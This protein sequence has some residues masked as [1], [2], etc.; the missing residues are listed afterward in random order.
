MNIYYKT[1]ENAI[2]SNLARRPF[3]D[4]TGRA[5]ISVE[6]CYQSW[7]SG[8]FCERTHS[9][10]WKGGTKYRGYKR[11]NSA[12]SEE[13]MYRILLMSFKQNPQ[14]LQALLN[15][16]NTQLTHVQD[17]TIWV[18]LF[19]KLLMQARDHFRK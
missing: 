10:K 11:V 12:V 6:H 7:K 8:A 9:R 16:G 15:T 1:C 13:I 14:A 17:K 19:P 3:T 5:Y 18:T 4:K 2:L